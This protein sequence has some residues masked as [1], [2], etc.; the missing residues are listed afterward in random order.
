MPI[1]EYQCDACGH[2][3]ELLRSFSEADK[4][5]VCKTCSSPSVKRQLSRC[6]T[7]SDGKATVSSGCA[8]CAGGSCASCR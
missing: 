2:K 3:F 7:H 6:N 4:P 8:G 5:A 1:Y